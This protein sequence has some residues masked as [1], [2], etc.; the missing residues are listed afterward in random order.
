MRVHSFG[1]VLSSRVYT[2]RT[3]WRHAPYQLAPCPLR[4]PRRSRPLHCVT[5]HLDP[6]LPHAA[7][8]I[9][10]QPC[11][12]HH[13]CIRCAR[14]D[15]SSR[16]TPPPRSGVSHRPD[17]R[18]HPRRVRSGTSHTPTVSAAHVAC[19]SFPTSPFSVSL[20]TPTPSS[21]PPSPHIG[22]TSPIRRP[23]ARPQ[24][25]VSPLTLPSLTR[26]ARP[27]RA[28]AFAARRTR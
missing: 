16:P 10:S 7:S 6:A 3:L 22:L 5:A 15:A 25:R 27:F 23:T 4:A 18:C 28:P 17:P 2:T 1:I 8:R 19:F 12:P 26:A 13:Q 20:C 14:G 9:P 21:C 11:T 24:T